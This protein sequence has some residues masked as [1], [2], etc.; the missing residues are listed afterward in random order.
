M[1]KQ[2]TDVL[3]ISDLLRDQ[4]VG[5]RTESW[6]V[7][8]MDAR[9]DSQATVAVNLATLLGK[10][11]KVLRLAVA[12]Y[13]HPSERRMKKMIRYNIEKVTGVLVRVFANLRNGAALAKVLF[14]KI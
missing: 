9:E 7:L 1:K 12:H 2:P 10:R 11:L 8:L 14:K 3:T 4:F 6:V 5:I 13:L